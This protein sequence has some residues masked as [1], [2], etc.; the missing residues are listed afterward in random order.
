MSSPPGTP[1]PSALLV[2]TSD[3]TTRAL[4]RK[5]LHVRAVEVVEAA[6]GVEALALARRLDLDLILLDAFLA[7]VDGISVCARIRAVPGVDQPPIVIIGLS[8]WRTVQLAFAEGADE[9][10]PKPLHPPLIRSRVDYLLR[11]RRQE[12]RLRLMERAV[13]AAG[14]GITILDG[15]SS[16]YPVT[17][18]NRAFLDMAG[19]PAPEILGKNLRLLRGPETEVAATTEL[20]DAM[21][22]GQ[23]T[24][25]LLRNYRKDGTPFWNDVS[26]SPLP[27][28]SGRVTH[29]V[30]VQTDVTARMVKSGKL[31]ATHL[32]E[33]ARERTRELEG[34]L[35]RVED[36]RRFT[37]TILNSMNAGVVTSD[38][39]GLISFANRAA[40]HI[41]GVSL[42]NCRGRSVLEIF[43]NLE[44]LREA[45]T[46]AG[47]R[48][49]ARVDF[50]LITP[51][52]GRLYVGMSVMRAPAEL[53]A[54]V[55][56]VF[57]FRDLAETLEREGEAEEDAAP[58]AEAEDEAAPVPAVT[59][60]PPAGA[61]EAD[62]EPSPAAAEAEDEPSVDAAVG[63]RRP[64]LALRY[65][66]PVEL[67]RQA[68]QTLAKSSPEGWPE[69]GIDAPEHLPE[70]LVDRQQ[71]VEALARLLDNAAHRSVDKARLR[72]RLAETEA[73][74][75]RG[76]KA[77]PFVRV[78]ILLPREEI[79]DEDLGAD[80]ESARRLQ[81]R[82][83]DL[84]TAEQL[85]QANGGRLVPSPPE[86]DVRS[87]SALIPMG[88][89]RE[90][91]G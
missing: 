16:E 57:L 48:H 10:L 34:V 51:G 4:L 37:E 88:S 8:S 60:L 70:V 78:D 26:T 82:R 35:T 39:S 11:R 43:G 32:E 77:E 46:R 84:A 80:G 30:A 18:A 20:R 64:H 87:L 65:C 45:M 75:E 13:E 83:Q 50:P 23:A 85:L 29:F 89:P 21:A 41:L 86:H 63:R 22:A 25:V 62:R 2:A 81:H 55:G 17:Y 40:L 36:R 52:G 53:E 56:Y 71:V 14:T 6:D 61:G 74:G 90:A 73:L 49:E 59:A 33:F 24:R 76:V 5:A 42:V 91:P 79:T 19:Y 1:S 3:S 67:V 28:V 69:V 31:D 47:A 66:A 27:D 15:R 72:V 7:V 44:E 68:A 54:E 38:L 9:I 12:N 58:G